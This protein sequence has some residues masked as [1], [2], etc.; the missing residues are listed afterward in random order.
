MKWHSGKQL[1]IRLRDPVLR[2]WLLDRGSLTDRLLARSAGDF[3]VELIGQRR[4]TAKPDEARAL[5]LGLRQAVI[6]R[7]VILCGRNEPWVF[8][9]SILPEKSL[10]HS[11]RHLK[12]LG[13]KPLGAVL[14]ADPHMHRGPIEVARI[15][16]P[17]L[18]A[19][20]ACDT[21]GRRSVFYLQKQPLLVSEVF[22]PGLLS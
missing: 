19:R 20:I 14:F 17:E 21:W 7:E 6:I 4:G 1:G 9:R 3:H 18:P 12:R 11:L 8:A 2:D 15:N 10:S 22:L 5:G 13:S 16:A